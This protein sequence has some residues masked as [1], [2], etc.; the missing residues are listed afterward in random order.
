MQIWQSLRQN[1]KSRS[2][3]NLSQ[4]WKVSEF[5]KFFSNR[6]HILYPRPAIT[7]SP[8]FHSNFKR[9]SASSRVNPC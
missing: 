6:L 4:L 1:E 9:T 3:E 2:T 7:L 5:D 8:L